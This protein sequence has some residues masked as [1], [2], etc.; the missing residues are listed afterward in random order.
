[1]SSFWRST[2][3]T[4]E[5]I[6]LLEDPE[7]WYDANVRF[8]GCINFRRFYN[9]PKGEAEEDDSDYIHICEIDGFIAR[10]QELKELA[11]K[12]FGRDWK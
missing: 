2:D 3:E 6:L 12:H 4:T 1:M 5:H 9:Q 11:K 8:D 7:K 10:L